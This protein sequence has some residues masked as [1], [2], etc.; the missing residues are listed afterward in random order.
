MKDVVGF[1]WNRGNSGKNWLKHS[2]SDQE[3]E[4]VFF[5]PKKKILLD[6]K[7]SESEPRYILLGATIRTRVLVIIFTK[8]KSLI[9]VISARDIKKKNKPFKN[10]DQ[11]REFWANFDLSQNFKPEDFKKVSFSNLKPSTRSI[12]IRIPE[13]LLVRLKEKA[14]KLNIPYQSLLKEYIATGV[15]KNT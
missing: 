12:S 14:N 5:D 15:T 9:R 1:Q 11:E 10:E 7:H 4:E 2:V 13:H 3:C 6:N 8:R